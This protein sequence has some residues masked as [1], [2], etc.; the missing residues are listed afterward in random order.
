MFVRMNNECNILYG[1]EVIISTLV[2][3][4]LTDKGVST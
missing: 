3:A 2:T 4:I 1:K